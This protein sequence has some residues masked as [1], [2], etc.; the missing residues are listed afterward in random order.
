MKFCS[1]VLMKMPKNV[2]GKNKKTLNQYNNEIKTFKM[3]SFEEI[4]QLL[5]NN[6]DEFLLIMCL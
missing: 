6:K 4:T 1:Y 5:L 2:F 3:P